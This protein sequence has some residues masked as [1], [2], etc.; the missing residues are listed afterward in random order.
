MGNGGGDPVL[1]VNQSPSVVQRRL[2]GQ[3]NW[4]PNQR[5]KKINSNW[6]ALVGLRC[7]RICGAEN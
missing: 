6:A 4:F 5:I 1:I 7:P 2:R 3:W